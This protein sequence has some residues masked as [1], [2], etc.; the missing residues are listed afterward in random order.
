MYSLEITGI[1][2]GSIFVVGIISF[3][4]W[5]LV[6]AEKIKPSGTGL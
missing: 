5:A 3:I 4:V 1:I 2:I 6:E